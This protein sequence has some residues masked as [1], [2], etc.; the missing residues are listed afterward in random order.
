M[1]LYKN[2]FFLLLIVS[3]L[4]YIILSFYSYEQKFS[5]EIKSFRA[6]ISHIERDNSDLKY[7][8]LQSSIYA[9]YNQDATAKYVNLLQLDYDHLKNESILNDSNYADV[10]NQVNK[11]NPIVNDKINNIQKYLIINAGIKNSFIFLLRE[12]SKSNALF[13]SNNPIHSQITSLITTFSN[14]R[15]ILDSDYINSNIILLES[16]KNY[17]P[18]QKEFVAKFN[19]HASYLKNNF[20]EFILLANVILENNI[21]TELSST[22]K[23]FDNISTHDTQILNYFTF[24]IITVSSILFG[25][26]IFLLIKIANENK[27]LKIT[28]T[29]LDYLLTHDKLTSLFNRYE[30]EQLVA[31]GNTLYTLLLINVDKFK[32]VNDLYGNSIGNKLLQEISKLIQLE[33]LRVYSP[34]YFRIGGDEFAILLQHISSH[35]AKIVA[36]SLSN[37]ILS[38]NFVLSDISIHVCVSIAINHEYPLLENADMTLKHIKKLPEIRYM[39][40]DKKMNFIETIKTNIDTINLVEH[41]ITE[42]RVVTFYQPILNIKTK[43]IEK[44]EALVRIINKDGSVLAPYAF[45]PI[46]QQTSLYQD[47]TKIVIENTLE[48]AKVNNYRFSINF[49]MQDI[50]NIPLMEIF[51]SQLESSKVSNLDIELLETEHLYNFHMIKDFIL[52]VK[53]FGCN[54]LI[55]DFGTGYSNFSYFS[56]FEIDILKID[57]SITKEINNNSKKLQIF[58]AI[59]NFSDA[60]STKTLAE[61]VENREIYKT[62][63]EIGITYAQ[64]YF[65]GK[66]SPTLLEDDEITI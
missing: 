52:K 38:H 35:D 58:K 62:I 51:F 64:G 5:S 33:M 18:K 56:E 10:K 53:T 2:I 4:F 63:E 22:N 34:K 26:I 37:T 55:D 21:N 54:I 40:F 57:G 28:Q 16:H 59:S 43:K 47:I 25:I 1:K 6:S 32:Q 45:L 8:I 65:I 44:Y 49:S 61:F 60:I 29:E 46:V 20:K 39:F 50:S 9:Y 13:P 30:F 23:V 66:P 19:L 41:A 36:N 31:S 15:R 12:A 7:N 17:T 3:G 24:F 42:D 48:K 27:T 11:L 14:A